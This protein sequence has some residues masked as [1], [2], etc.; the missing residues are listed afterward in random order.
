MDEFVKRRKV[1]L[2]DYIGQARNANKELFF[3]FFHELGYCIYYPFIELIITVT[4]HQI[5]NYG[6]YL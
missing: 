4:L 1:I 3:L 2:S 5:L 6:R